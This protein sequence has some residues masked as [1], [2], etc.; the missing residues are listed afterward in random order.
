MPEAKLLVVPKI[1]DNADVAA[2]LALTVPLK[3]TLNPLLVALP[4]VTV[5]AAAG[6]KLRMEP[7][8]DP[9]A[10]VAVSL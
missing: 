7:E 2:P 6:T 9:L 4:V 10:F 8:L 1:I 3:V 5:G